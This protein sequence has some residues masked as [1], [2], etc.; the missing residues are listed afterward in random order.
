MKTWLVI[1]SVVAVLLAASI[2]VGFWLLMDTRA[3]LTDTKIELANIKTELAVAEARL[4][5]IRTELTEIRKQEPPYSP[6]WWEQ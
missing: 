3:E 6:P 2:G 1:V 5:D 4:T